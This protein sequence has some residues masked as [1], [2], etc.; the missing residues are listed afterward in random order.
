[1]RAQ[2]VVNTTIGGGSAICGYSFDQLDSIA[3]GVNTSH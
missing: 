1:V 2:K 3:A